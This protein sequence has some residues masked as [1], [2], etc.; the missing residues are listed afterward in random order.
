AV[1]N[2]EQIKNELK[3]LKEAHP[4]ASHY[5]YA[6]RLGTEGVEFRT[7][8]NGEPSGS[9]GRP[10]MRQIDKAVVTNILVVVVRYFGGALLGIPG[11]IN[12]Y[13]TAAADCLS[14]TTLV[15]KEICRSYTISFD[16]TQMETVMQLIKSLELEVM[17]RE[18][19]L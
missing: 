14:E 19:A 18:M 4:K 9:A 1:E 10:I 13:K 3:A 7:S 8:D 17:N 2:R 5:C 11:L 6:W 16:Y 15:E 12:A